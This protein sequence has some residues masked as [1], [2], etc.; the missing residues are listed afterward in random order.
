MSQNIAT[1]FYRHS[2]KK[3]NV[4]DF[5]VIIIDLEKPGQRPTVCDTHLGV[6]QYVG[7]QRV[8]RHTIIVSWPG[9]R[10]ELL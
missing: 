4:A 10:K 9:I 3:L 8:D 1:T 5:N 6:I 2:N 7:I